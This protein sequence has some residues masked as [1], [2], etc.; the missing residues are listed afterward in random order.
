LDSIIWGN[1][2]SQIV[3]TGEKEP[4][5][6]YTDVEGWWPD[7]GNLHDDP[8]FARHGY[9]AQANAPDI[10]VAPGTPDAIWMDGDY[11]LKS[12]AGRWDPGMMT[13]VLD[14]ITSSC[15]DAG[16]R[17]SPVGQEPAPN[18]DIVNMGAYGG[19]AQAS[20]S[21]GRAEANVTPGEH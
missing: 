10:A 17:T 21:P 14:A 1:T 15:V 3:A 6:T 5:I 18:G 11:H 2:P 19:S 7:W 9:W 8:L 4:S 20:K 12:Q 13:W 16:D